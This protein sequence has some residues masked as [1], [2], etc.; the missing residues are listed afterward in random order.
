MIK[1]TNKEN[2]EKADVMSD[3]LYYYNAVNDAVSIVEQEAGMKYTFRSE[4]E[5]QWEQN[6]M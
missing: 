4:K 5:L 1:E 6:E 2:L 3:N